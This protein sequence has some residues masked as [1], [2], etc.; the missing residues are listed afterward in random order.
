[1][2]AVGTAPTADFLAILGVLLFFGLL[3]PRI[4]RPLHLPLATSLILVGSV[5][6]PY[7][8]DLVV[9]DPGIELFGFLG[10]TFHML[11]AG[12]HARALG[13][14]PGERRATRLLVPSTAIPAVTG[15]WIARWFGYDW[16][17][18]L[19]VGTVFLSSSIM[20]VF[21]AVG[22]LHLGRSRAG[23]L[24]ER[25][26][27]VQDL[28][29]SVLALTLFERMAPHPRYPFPILAG[30]LLSSVIVLRMFLPEVVGYLVKRFG[31]DEGGDHEARLRVVIAVM[32]LVIFAYST[33]AVQPVVAAFL[34]GFALA[35]VS[36]FDP[37]RRRLETLGYALFIPVFLFVVGLETDLTLL[38]RFRPDELLAVTVIGGAV[39]SKLVG[40][41]VGSRW[42]GLTRAEATWIAVASTMKLTVP[43]SVTYVARDLG[44]IDTTMFS[45]LVMLSVVTSLGAP[46][47]LSLLTRRTAPRTDGG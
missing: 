10:A 39:G 20:L 7:G 42:A 38:V 36:N 33:F 40:G 2:E 34:V 13:I 1:M 47:F 27:V 32:L 4:L 43:L 14:R 16:L 30:L 11:L 24:L 6:G 21:G 44:L 12:T 9:A 37:L 8:M 17:A 25:V 15:V 29:A 19:F 18:A 23:R 22:A 5:T 26:A 28:A 3:A 31:D 45:A 46:L 41:F 35:G